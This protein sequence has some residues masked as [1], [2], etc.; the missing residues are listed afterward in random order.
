MK[1]LRPETLGI[2]ERV[3]ALSGRPIAFKPDSSLSLRATLQ[4][5]R[6][7]A[8]A[9]VLRY[10]PSNDPLDYWVAYQAGYV[11]RLFE[12]PADERCDF[13]GTGEGAEDVET[14]LKTGQPLTD[15]D[16]AVLP[17]F[18]QMTAQWAMLN[19]RSS[20]IGMRIDHEDALARLGV[21]LV[22]HDDARGDAS[23]VEEVRGQPD[24]ALDVAAFNDLAPD[25]RF[26]PAPEQNSVGQNDG[27]LAGAL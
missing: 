12:L 14:L 17:S 7:G 9:H 15:A 4:V 23:A 24:D 21:L 26:G 6:N 5:A 27:P 25:A 13:A 8:A 16:Q 18:A 2:V 19:L 20:A 1:N 3:Q 11:L 22:E 10:R